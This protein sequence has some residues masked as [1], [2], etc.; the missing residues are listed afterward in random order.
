MQPGIEVNRKLATLAEKPQV[1]SIKIAEPQHAETRDQC[2]AVPIDMV[3]CEYPPSIG[4]I[5]DYT[6]E[7]AKGLSLSGIPVRIWAPGIEGCE[8]VDPKITISRSLGRFGMRSLLRAGRAMRRAGGG[9]CL[10][11]Q[12]EPVG[13]G[14][15][16][17]NLP[18]CLWV[19]LQALGGTRLIVMFHE[20]FLRYSKRTPKRF[21]GATLQRLMAF[22]LVNSAAKVFVSTA[23]GAEAIAKLSLE[24]G[25][26]QHLPVFSNIKTNRDPVYSHLLR[27]EMVAPGETLVG[28]FGR[29][30]AEIEALAIPALISLLNRN[31]K[32]KV[33][34]AGECASAYRSRLLRDHEELAPRVHSA[35]IC[36]AD[37]IASLLGACDF[38]FQPYPDGIT[39][40][41]STTMAALANGRF[42]VSNSGAG[43]ESL[44]N[45]TAA[46]HLLRGTTACEQAE[47][48]DRLVRSPERIRNGSAEA[49]LF[50][51]HNFSAEHTLRAVSACAQ[52]H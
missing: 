44:W 17:V 20:T 26:V 12:W 35:G 45:Q 47:E 36:S 51:D 2:L 33:M 49:A 24:T 3:T 30:N 46:V 1:V 34:F 5:A 14:A 48:M 13:Y 21:I 19:A 43:T 8:Q 10:L 40:R 28:H 29:Y 32:V 22:L 18:F 31:D 25:K 11:L 16:S 23:D 50:Y 38:M 4:G 27:D 7:I 15:M 41:R 39:T 9:R 52:A 6:R 42:L 37:E